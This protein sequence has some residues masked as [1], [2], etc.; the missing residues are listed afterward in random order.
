MSKAKEIMIV[1]D[2]AGIRAIL[3][4][5]LAD[6]GFNVTLARDGKD[7]Y[8]QM[9]DRRFDLLI[10]DIN[11]PNINGI[12]LLKKMKQE[13]R[14]ERVIVMTGEPIDH[15]RF[16]QEIQPVFVQLKKPF[17]MK[18]FLNAVSS[19]LEPQEEKAA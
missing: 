16:G 6:K 18:N 12:E 4:E 17:R 15:S 3:F 9:R 14:G 10:T 19:A 2:E 11:M 5:A 7:S 1:D 13:N 8:C